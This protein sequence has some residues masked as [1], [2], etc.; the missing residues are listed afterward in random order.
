MLLFSRCQNLAILAKIDNK[1]KVKYLEA[2]ILGI[3]FR[4]ASFICVGQTLLPLRS[5]FMG[6][7]KFSA[8]LASN[9]CK[10]KKECLH[11]D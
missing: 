2:T 3:H 10:M 8:Y 4:K 6:T 1:P 5:D 9:P 7:G 11:V